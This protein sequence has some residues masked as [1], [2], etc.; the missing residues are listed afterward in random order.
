ME[1][2]QT[3]PTLA[4]LSPRVEWHPSP[5]YVPQAQG[6]L[7]ARKALAEALG[8][9]ALFEQLCLTSGSSEALGMALKMLADAGDEVLLGMPG[10]PLAETL[11]GFEG[12]R[13][14][15]F[16]LRLEGEAF[17]WDVPL[18]EERLSP[19]TRAVLLT[20][21]QVPTGCC[22][23]REEV[24]ALEAFCAAH[25]L[26]LLI[27]QVF[28][29][30]QHSLAGHPW[31][32][33]TFLLGG[34]SKWLGLPQHK[35][36]WTWVLGPKPLA[37]EALQRWLWV[38]DAYLCVA[39]PVQEAVPTWLPLAEGFQSRVEARCQ[40]NHACLTKLR[41]EGAAW[42][43]FAR[44]AGWM[45]VL[46]V[47]MFPDE[48]NL[49]LALLKAGVVVWPGYFFDM[50]LPGFLVLSLLLEEEAFAKAA[51]CMVEALENALGC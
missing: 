15:P 5:A 31:K 37:E 9:P 40:N 1:L 24:L 51:A 42:S 3:N 25:G 48:E 4:G 46:R 14:V 16:A 26:A 29:L 8:Q 36:A 18:L 23:L 50:P 32:C 12:L 43:V 39:T 19:H 2:T 38:A 27:D 49:A 11:A 22:L 6:L 34:L 17:R 45:A 7:L 30:E 21:P 35:L 44:E 28:A 20:S 33:L 41:P 10:Y 47:P 13:C